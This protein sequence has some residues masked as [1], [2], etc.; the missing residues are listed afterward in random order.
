[1]FANAAP[2]GH[3]SITTRWR[4]ST[5]QQLLCLRAFFHKENKLQHKAACSLSCQGSEALLPAESVLWHL[6]KHSSRDHSDHAPMGPCTCASAMAGCAARALLQGSPSP[7]RD[8]NWF[9][10]K[11]KKKEIQ[12]LKAHKPHLFKIHFCKHINKDIIFHFIS[13]WIAFFFF[14]S[15]VKSGL[16]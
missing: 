2:E 15:F 12:P 8:W 9:K 13:I 3:Q 16:L 6:Q 14:F 5:V 7:L 1:M 10:M 11:E 4:F